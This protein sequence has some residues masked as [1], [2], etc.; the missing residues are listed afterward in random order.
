MTDTP[1][2]NFEVAKRNLHFFWLVD[3]SSSMNHNGKIQSLNQAI[4]SALPEMRKAA[5]DNPHVKLFVRTIKFGSQASWV[6]TE[7]TL[8]EDFEW[9]DLKADGLTAMGGALEMVAEAMNIENMGRRNIPPVVAIVTD[10]FA[11]DDFEAA[12]VKLNQSPWGRKCIKVAVAIGHDADKA[13]L[14]KFIDD[15]NIPVLEAHNPQQLVEYI[16]WASTQAVQAASSI[17]STQD[18]KK[19]TINAPEPKVEDADDVF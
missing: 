14:T 4:R 7:P 9:L 13:L 2:P 17:N 11:T 8:V 15:P 18:D 16:K 1:I 10:G 12:I 6:T 19:A 5:E 3:A